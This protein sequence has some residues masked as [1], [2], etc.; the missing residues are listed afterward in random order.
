MPIRRYVEH[1]V[2]RPEVL[3]AMNKAFGDA[4]EILNI[5]SDEIRRGAVAQFIIGMARLDGSL[6]SA[7]LR[8]RAVDE[9][10]NPIST[11]SIGKGEQIEARPAQPRAQP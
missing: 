9:F 2:F 10:R 8:D 4:T 1:G 11:A 7:T 6:D 3:S 5:G